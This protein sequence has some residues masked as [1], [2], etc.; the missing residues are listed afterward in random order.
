MSLCWL[1]DCFWRIYRNCFDIRIYVA[2]SDMVSPKMHCGMSKS[3]FRRRKWR[4]ISGFYFHIFLKLFNNNISTAY[5]WCRVCMIGNNEKGN[6]SWWLSRWWSAV[7]RLLVSWLRTPLG[8]HGCYFLV[9]FVGCVGNGR[10][11]G[12]IKC[13]EESYRLC[14]C[15]CACVCVRVRVCARA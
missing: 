6:W 2:L 12:P 8:G 11:D 4:S 10:C 5:V 9:F 1:S 14:V 7:S 13:S 15:V 3:G